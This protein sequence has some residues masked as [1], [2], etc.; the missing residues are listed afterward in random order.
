MEKRLLQLYLK[1]IQKEKDLWKK[2]RRIPRGILVSLIISIILIV[3]TITTAILS[4]ID[5]KP[6]Q[7]WSIVCFISSII[8]LILAYITGA[9]SSFYMEKYE[10][11]I[12][13]ENMEEYWKK[14][15]ED[16]QW[17]RTVFPVNNESFYNDIVHIKERIDKYKNEL[18]IQAENRIKRRDEWTRILIIP[19]VLLIISVV[20]NKNDNFSKALYMTIIIL[21]SFFVC[22]IIALDIN[23]ILD[24]FRRRK[25]EQVK[26][27]SD[28]L[29]GILD[30]HSFKK[31]SIDANEP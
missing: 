8:T 21:I 4:C 30:Y 20:V 16:E 22:Y 28:S 18:T 17:I 11:S 23:S 19:I 25:E 2:I 9:I 29:Q 27:F 5:I 31:N 15:A 6:L 13:D 26:L 3:I 12:A 24:I 7:N 1:K 10:I 14:S